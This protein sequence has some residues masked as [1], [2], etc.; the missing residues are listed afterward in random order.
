[1]RETIVRQFKR[2]SGVLGRLAGW[3]MAHRES[4]LRRNQWAVS[5]LGIAPDH[6]VL[7]IGCGPGIALGHAAKQATRGGVYGLDHSE[8]MVHAARRRNAAAVEA[9]RVRVVH[10]TA[11]TAVDLGER[12]DR[13]LAVNVLQ[14]WD[15]PVDTL[16]ALRQIMSQDGMIAIV[17]Q[18]RNKGANDS[19]ARRGA[20]R[21]E[22]LL[23]EAGFRSV[24]TETLDLDPIVT[25][26][27]GRI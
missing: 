25:C 11:E 20:E 5:Q 21:N 27:L 7:E 3:V 12:F 22:Q 1:M 4:N 2:P 15:A 16:R 23:I 26:V 17:F 14:F 6:K 18:P 10:G 19:D 24:Q 8:L 13:V 9:G